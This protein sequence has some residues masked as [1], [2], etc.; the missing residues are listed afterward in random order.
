M[1]AQC[2]SGAVKASIADLE[3]QKIP[4]YSAE[5]NKTATFTLRCLYRDPP[6]FALVAVWLVLLLVGCRCLCVCVC[7]VFGSIFAVFAFITSHCTAFSYIA[8]RAKGVMV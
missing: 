7:V 3:T 1:T 2:W 6:V 8:E 5:H 4:Y